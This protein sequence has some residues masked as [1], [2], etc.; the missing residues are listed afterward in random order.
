MAYNTILIDIDGTVC[1]PGSSL[2]E[3]ARYALSEMGIHET[4]DAALRRFVGPPLEHSFRD[5]YGFDESQTKRAVSLFRTKLQKDGIKQYKPYPGIADVL[6][7]L[8]TAGKTTA[9]VTSK[10]EHIAKAALETTGLLAYFD[11]IGA[12]QP[13]EVVDKA[14]ILARVLQQLP[15][16]IKSEIVMV[17][18][19]KHDVEAAAIH[20]IDS[21]GVLW[22]YGS[23]DELQSEGATYIVND[24]AELLALL[25]EARPS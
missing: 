5:Y 24:A 12:Q 20:G 14:V 21:I 8:H 3:S 25:L 23:A 22:G 2:I 7:S 10:V 15:H 13:D 1:D 16:P 19:R 17:G 4:D 18:D 11:I 6:K 9:I